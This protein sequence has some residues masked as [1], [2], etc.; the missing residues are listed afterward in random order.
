[1]N[2][3][4]QAYRVMRFVFAALSMAVFFCSSVVAAGSDFNAGTQEQIESLN[5]VL[6]QA[7]LDIPQ[8]GLKASDGLIDKVYEG[9]RVPVIVRLREHDRPYGFFADRQRPRSTMINSLQDTVLDAISMQTQAD[10][11]GQHV[12]RFSMLPAMALQVDVLELEALLAHP[13]VIDIVEDIPV[14]PALQ[15]SVPLIGAGPD[16][17]FST[18]TGLGQAVAILDTGVD[19]NHPFLSGKVVSEA[20]YSSNDSY[21]GSTSL[22]PGGVQSSEAI[23]SGLPCDPLVFGCDH[24]T[25]VAGIAAGSNDTFSGVAKDASIIAIQVFSLF[26]ADSEYCDGSRCVLSYTRDQILGLERVYALRNTYTIASVNMSISGGMYESPCDSES[27]KPIIDNLRAAGIATVISS[28]NDGYTNAIG[29]PACIDSSISVGSTTK[30]DEVSSFSNSVD[31]LSLLAPGSSI[32]SSVPGTGY[33]YWNGTSMAAP[34]VAGAWAVLKQAQP[35]A[36]VAEVLDAFQS[37]GL[38]IPD[39]RTGTGNRVKPRI[40]V[41]NALAVLSPCETSADCDD[42]VVCN[43]VET[44]LGGTCVP[45]VVSCAADEVCDEQADLCV[46]C[47]EDDHCASGYACF[48]GTCAPAG[49]MWIDKSTVKAGKTAGTD[50]MQLKGLLDASEVDFDAADEVVVSL[51][52][53]YIP[54]S[55]VIEYSFPV[56]AEFLKKGTYTS[57]KIKPDDKADTLKSLAIDTNKGTMKFSVKNAD[58]TGLSCPITCRVTIGDDVYIAEMIMNEGL[59]NGTKK[60]CPLPLLM[61]V[62]ASLDATKVKAKK[63]TKTE[64]DSISI[65]GTFTIDGEFDTN[66]PLIITL[67]SDEFNVPGTVFDEKKGSYSYK[68]YDTGDGLV[69]VKFDTVKCSY[70]ISIKSTTLSGSGPVDLEIDFFDNFLVC[71]SQIN[72][73]LD[74]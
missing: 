8:D 30:E 66:E 74:P 36:T 12:K 21:Y 56:A 59:V 32:Q 54:D 15:D 45:G 2:C 49:E 5:A 73:P 4:Y 67:G 60:P 53:E 6:E 14:P 26:P 47:F 51:T 1:M 44:C 11:A 37:T 17:S 9:R 13:N 62:Y 41:Q 43:G 38:S 35:D 25:H 29:S 16:G 22:C 50:S 20:C 7:F 72:L 46:E 63:S 55:G 61:G 68:S 10:K 19:K 23:D 24:G 71:S 65:S 40:D 39:T 70:S 18:Y 3:S 42:G 33:V 58:L 31:F 57:P 69:T 28:G 27:Q 64:S 52:A 48:S 34:H